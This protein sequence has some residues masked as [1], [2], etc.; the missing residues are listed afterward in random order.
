MTVYSYAQLESLWISAGGSRATAPIAA[1]I[2]EAESGGNSDSYNPKD[3]NGWPSAGLWQINNGAP[4]PAGWSNPATNARMAVAKY[5]ASLKAKGNGWLPWGTYTSGAYKAF[6]NSKTTPDPNVPG[7]PTGV[8]AQVSAQGAGDCL[9]QNP[10]GVSLPVIG[11]ISA[12][13]AC[14]F[15]YS[16]ARA[17]ISAGLLAAGTVVGFAGIAVLAAAAGMKAAPIIA[18]QARGVGRTLSYVPGMNSTGQQ[19]ASAGASSRQASPKPTFRQ[20]A[21]DDGPEYTAADQ[22]RLGEPRENP[23]LEVRGGAVRESTA[24]RQA[25]V[26]RQNAAARARAR[27]AANPPKRATGSE[28]F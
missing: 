2:A 23:D 20:M 15:S 5:N 21:S 19:V 9:I 6:L 7:S 4:A 16:N 24:D 3:T 17:F 28:P 12:G 18:G 1:A 25:R 8:S 11:S 26:R 22:R 10:L 14:L 27:R 13:P